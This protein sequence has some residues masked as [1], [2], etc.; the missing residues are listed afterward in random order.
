MEAELIERAAEELRAAG[1]VVQSEVALGDPGRHKEP[2][3]ADIVAWAVT[4]AGLVPAVVVDVTSNVRRGP[5]KD[6]VARLMAYRN[7]AGAIEARM[8]DGAWWAPEPFSSQLTAAGIPQ[9]SADELEA[10]RQQERLRHGVLAE[11]WKELRQERAGGPVDVNRLRQALD[12]LS[13]RDVTLTAQLARS[14]QGARLLV[15]AAVESLDR[16]AVGHHTGELLNMCLASLSGA[17]HGLVVDPFCGTAGTLRQVS[18]GSASSSVVFRGRDISGDAIELATLLCD[19]AGVDVD[20]SV[21][22]S[23]LDPVAVEADFVVSDPPSGMKL[24]VPFVLLTGTSTREG[25][26]AVVDACLR[27]LKPEG[28]AVIVASASFLWRGGEVARYRQWLAQNLRLVAVF[29]LPSGTSRA[30]NVSSAVVV[31]EKRDPTDTLLA[32][33]GQ[34]WSM[35]LQPSGPLYEAYVSHRE[36]T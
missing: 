35:Q 33:V 21:G 22:D 16:W 11:L 30:T 25:D 32:S 17:D 8:Y 26:V 27:S 28:R 20:L 18:V 13:R 15:D 7:L 34:D 9:I 5:S 1:F 2:H 24:S 10:P 29:T 31:I 23:L 14:H 19:I 6:L 4:G 3:R 36:S 12:N